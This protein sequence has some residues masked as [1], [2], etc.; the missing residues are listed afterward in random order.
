[1]LMNLLL[2][3]AFTRDSLNTTS[4]INLVV[5][6]PYHA[7]DYNISSQ[8]FSLNALPIIIL[9]AHFNVIFSPPVPAAA[10][11]KPLTEMTR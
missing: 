6:V 9:I 11:L 5:W 3:G 2:Q 1:M 8:L 10:R 4:I 7:K